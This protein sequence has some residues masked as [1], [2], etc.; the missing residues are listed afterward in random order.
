VWFWLE[1]Q[2]NAVVREVKR[3]ELQ[4]ASLVEQLR[5]P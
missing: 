2:K 3:L 4:V 5:R 1:R